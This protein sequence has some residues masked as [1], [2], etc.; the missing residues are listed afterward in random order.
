MSKKSNIFI[1]NA[2]FL[3]FL[4]FSLTG[5]NSS[6][7]EPST[8]EETAIETITN[9]VTTAETTTEKVTM[10]EPSTEVTTETEKLT[11]DAAFIEFTNELFISGIV[12]NTINLHYTISNPE[13]Y[14]IENYPITLGNVSK[15]AFEESYIATKECLKLMDN[16]IYD[17]LN[18]SNQLTY[19]IL[20]AYFKI[21]IEYKDYYLY[22]SYLSPTTGIQAQLP[23]LLAEYRF[24]TKQDIEDYLGL[25]KTIDS[26]YSSII[27][28]E[29]LKSDS[30]LFMT[31]EIANQIIAQ[32][33]SFISEPENNYLLDTFNDKLDELSTLT[34]NEKTNYK[35]RN[36]DL[37]K[38]NVIPAYQI[39]IDGLKSLQGTGI[40]EGGLC[41]FEGGT[42]YYEYLLKNYVGTDTPPLE[43]LERIETQLNDDIYLLQTIIEN[44]PEVLDELYSIDLPDS[45]PIEMVEDLKVKM[46]NDYPTPPDTAYDIKYVHESLEEHLSPAFYLVPPIDDIS[47]N[48]I[49]INNGIDYSNLG[50]YTMLAHE[51][52]PGHLYQSIYSN[53]SKPNNVRSLLGFG[54]YVEG[55][56]TYVEMRSFAYA[57]LDEDLLLLSQL[58]QSLSLALYCLIDIGVNYNGWDLDTAVEYLSSTIGISD[59]ESTSQIYY[60]VIETPANY[61]R[62]YYG[63]LNFEDLRTKTKEALGDNFNL[64]DFHRVILEVGPCSFP[65]LEKYLNIY[66]EEELSKSDSSSSIH[67]FSLYDK[68]YSFKFV[69]AFT[70]TSVS[71]LE[72][73]SNIASIIFL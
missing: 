18:S 70:N 38:S 12:E 19:D 46:A 28:F 58:D 69:N 34:N 49:Y 42:Q 29:Q 67:N 68:K 15:Q 3:L 63:Y 2:I 11:T 6:I 45:T 27:A 55:W 47:T 43:V 59:V 24:N 17:E 23:I 21:E 65:I 25:L 72:S 13:D 30:G 10:E 50:L 32:C 40:N 66:I 4:I 7:T 9:E 20:K 51:G 37:L 16:F 31:D 35:T 60:A 54:G 1:R 71:L 5:C 57:D 22:T 41:N 61:L 44:N 36:A 52:Y 48:S 73:P 33:E 53:I 26:Y 14:E 62:Y 39:I 8:T 64:Q 56:A